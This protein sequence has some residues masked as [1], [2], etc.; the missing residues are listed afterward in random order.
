[1][2]MLLDHKVTPRQL[3]T[4]LPNLYHD[5][6]NYPLTMRDISRCALPS[7]H[8]YFLNP[9][10]KVTSPYGVAVCQKLKEYI[11]ICD[12]QLMEVYLKQVSQTLGGI[13][14]RQRG[15]QYGFGDDAESDLHIMKNMDEKML[16]DSDA[17]NTKSIENYFGNLD[18]EIKKAGAQGFDKCCDDLIIKYGRDLVD[19]Q[20]SWSTKANRK[21][22][23]ELKIKQ[24]LFDKKQKVLMATNIDEEDAAKLATSNK[25]IRCVSNCKKTHNGP[26]TTVEE[27]NELVRNWKFSEK[28]LHSTL[29]LEIRFRKFTFYK[30]K[31]TCPLF[32]QRGLSVEQKIKNLT[33]LIG[34]QLEFKVLADMDDLEKAINE[35]ASTEVTYEEM[36]T[37]QHEVNGH[38]DDNAKE[39]NKVKEVSL[40][41]LWS[42]CTLLI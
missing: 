34:S 23:D 22:A 9:H 29:D 19:G 10:E 14:K 25:V 38:D 6:C 11:E 30:V 36:E 28:A 32:K 26:L 33:T 8:K 27:L 3:L 12:Q 35:T 41:C 40:I 21:L 20:H 16:D 42:C 5:L 2:S 39:I 37:V 17:T 18:R 4:I 24:H 1:M 31:A 13:L 7:L 15:D